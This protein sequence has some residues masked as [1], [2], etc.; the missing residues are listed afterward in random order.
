MHYV[1]TKNMAVCL[2]RTVLNDIFICKASSIGT[3]FS[4]GQQWV[5]KDFS[6]VL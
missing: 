4:E 6:N 3:D 5:F 1:L 2:E